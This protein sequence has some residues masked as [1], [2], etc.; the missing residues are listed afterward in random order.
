MCCKSMQ[1]FTFMYTYFVR[2][3]KPED[4]NRVLFQLDC[5]LDEEREQK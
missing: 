2:F 3:S 4:I 5:E 1:H